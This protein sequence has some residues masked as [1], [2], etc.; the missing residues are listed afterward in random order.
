MHRQALNRTTEANGP[1][2]VLK[3]PRQGAFDNAHIAP[4]MEV[5]L[6][7]P[8][9][10]SIP[11]TAVSMAPICAHD[12]FHIHWR[13]S[14]H[15][16]EE[17]TLG[18]GSSGPYTQRGAPMVHPNQTVT[19]STDAGVVGF[20]YQASAASQRAG[21]WMV[22]MPHGA[23]YAVRVVVSPSVILEKLLSQAGLP[24]AARAVILGAVSG[25]EERAFAWLYFFLQFWPALQSRPALRPLDVLT[26]DVPFLT[27]L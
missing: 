9:I 10:G 18:W 2:V 22:V 16:T 27:A 23:A 3:L 8:L 11:S 21:E 26:A 7:I 20:R 5:S 14:Q 25:A 12:C 19:F 24:A 15:Y 17:H 6:S 4:Q 13:W 1:S